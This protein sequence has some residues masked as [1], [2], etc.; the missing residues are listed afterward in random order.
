MVGLI[1]PV[2]HIHHCP[3][4]PHEWEHKTYSCTADVEL[5]CPEHE[6]K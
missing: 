6:K 1:T 2:K 5:P 4:G 3:N